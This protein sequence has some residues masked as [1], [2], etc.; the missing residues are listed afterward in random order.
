M[1]GTS[2][3]FGIE[4]QEVDRAARELDGFGARLRSTGESL[5]STGVPPRESLPGGAAAEAV[6]V[7]ADCVGTTATSEGMSNEAASASLRR[8]VATV[9]AEDAASASCFRGGC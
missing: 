5:R 2:D 1:T 7:A 3:M 8:F 6:T 4:P 9:S